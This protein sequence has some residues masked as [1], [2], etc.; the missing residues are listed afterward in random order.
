MLFVPSDPTRSPPLGKLLFLA[1]MSSSARHLSQFRL[2]SKPGAPYETFS[3]A[4]GALAGQHSTHDCCFLLYALYPAV[5]TL[6]TAAGII[7]S[8]TL[9]HAYP[10]ASL[11][12]FTSPICSVCLFL[13]PCFPCS[14]SRVYVHLRCV[15]FVLFWSLPPPGTMWF[16][17]RQVSPSTA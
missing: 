1:T 9:M 2:H 15:C 8:V 10:F 3:T 5:W 11:L 17:V 13:V 6:S 16:I 12:C 4:V 7:L 14:P